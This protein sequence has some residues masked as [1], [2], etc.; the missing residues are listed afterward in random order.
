MTHHPPHRGAAT[1]L[2]VALLGLAACSGGAS[3]DETPA[4]PATPTV[5][6]MTFVAPD[7]SANAEF[8][9]TADGPER[10]DKHGTYRQASIADDALVLQYEPDVVDPGVAALYAPEDVAAAHRAAV[11][12]F[13]TEFID[14]EVVADD[15]E[16]ARAAAGSR[17]AAALYPDP[18][19]RGSVPSWLNEEDCE[20]LSDCWSTA[21]DEN[22]GYAP[23]PYGEALRFVL[24]SFGT[25]EITAS[26]YYDVIVTLSAGYLRE[27]DV[28]D[29]PH[30]VETAH[31]RTSFTMSQVDGEWLILGMDVNSSLFDVES[32]VEGGSESLPLLDVAA[33]GVVP[34]GFVETTFG[35]VVLALP[36]QWAPGGEDRWSW[37]NVP[38]DTDVEMDAFLGPVLESTSEPAGLMVWRE[39]GE[40]EAQ[41]V[42]TSNPDWWHPV[43]GSSYRLD[44]EG[45]EEAFARIEP[46]TSTQ[47]A[48][49]VEI[50]LVL[51]DTENIRIGTYADPGEGEDTLREI[52]ET[53]SVS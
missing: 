34:D 42:G 15:S 25:A 6:P 47:E 8:G 31:V 32:L 36:A 45:T 35:E 41:G 22:L 23:V 12:Y 38:E 17:I 2:A 39:P 4:S 16:E 27:I 49:F 11:T 33:S 44:V 9:L 28:P 21:R 46:A 24:S 37:T 10:T 20:G 1:L 14:S 29:Q 7:R 48:E 30:A 18:E 50:T 3:A 40:V 19:F 51:A 53:L 43:G 13:L 5:E 52:V 26:E